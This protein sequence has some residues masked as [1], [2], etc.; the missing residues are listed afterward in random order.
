MPIFRAVGKVVDDLACAA[1]HKAKRAPRFP[2]EPSCRRLTFMFPLLRARRRTRERFRTRRGRHDVA[3]V[4]DGVDAVLQH[5]FAETGW[6][7]LNGVVAAWGYQLV[8]RR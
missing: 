4:V 2:A 3:V 1:M 7:A 5:L 6:I 8:A